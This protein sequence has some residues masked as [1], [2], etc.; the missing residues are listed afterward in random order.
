MVRA[1]INKRIPF[2]VVFQAITLLIMV[3]CWSAN[4]NGQG[5][6]FNLRF[7]YDNNCLVEAS[8]FIERDENGNVKPHYF[9]VKPDEEV[10]FKYSDGNSAIEEEGEMVAVDGQIRI[11]HRTGFAD[12]AEKPEGLQSF[13]TIGRW[14]AVERAKGSDNVWKI[15]ADKDSVLEDFLNMGALEGSPLEIPLYLAPGF[16]GHLKLVE[17]EDAFVFGKAYHGP[18]NLTI[19]WDGVAVAS[20]VNAANKNYFVFGLVFILAVLVLI[21]GAAI[22]V[23][24]K[25]RM[26]QPG[27]ESSI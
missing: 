27:A 13:R 26:Q 19:T 10:K 22:L 24:R 6:L 23:I 14:T 25:R 9:D 15:E 17:G 21:C 11:H 16:E 20:A 3:H 2:G 5:P 1:I 7:V 12:L 18:N 8:F 4:A